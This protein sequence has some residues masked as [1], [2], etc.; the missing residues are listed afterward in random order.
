MF[1]GAPMNMNALIMLDMPY[2]KKPNS[3]HDHVLQL[4]FTCTMSDGSSA[5]Q[6]DWSGQAGLNNLL[7]ASVASNFGQHRIK[8]RVL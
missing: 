8:G 7:A 1:M 4:Q 6:P 2:S 5:V 3:S